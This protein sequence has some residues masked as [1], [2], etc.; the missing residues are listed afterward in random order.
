V[1]G[2]YGVILDFINFI[3]ERDVI[4]TWIRTYKILRYSII[5]GAAGYV[6]S[7]RNEKQR[8]KSDKIQSDSP[9]NRRLKLRVTQSALGER[10]LDVDVMSRNGRVVV[11]AVPTGPGGAQ[12]LPGDRIRRV[13]GER[14]AS[15]ADF[16]LAVQRVRQL[17][18]KLKLG[19]RREVN[20]DESKVTFCLFKMLIFNLGLFQT[21]DLQ[22]LLEL[23]LNDL[24]GPSNGE[25]FVKPLSSLDY[26]AYCNPEH[27]LEIGNAFA[28]RDFW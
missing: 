12:L 1:N 13:N 11:V 5:S 10:P 22:D 16:F 6:N 19:I 25:R 20:H 4:P 2:I 9:K 17:G 21:T 27:E 15:A 23:A 26:S 3:I 28:I 24:P 8:K 7:E 18:V 14:I